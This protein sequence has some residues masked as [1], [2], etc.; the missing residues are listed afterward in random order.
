M[1][2]ELDNGYIMVKEIKRSDNESQDSSGIIFNDQ[3]LD[4][5]QVSQGT[6]IQ[7][8][9]KYKAGDT[10]LFHKV[11]PV[12]VHMKLEGDE[13]LEN[14]YFIKSTDVICKITK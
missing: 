14:Y 13:R 6:I 4:D 10:I 1:L 12:D 5:E 3:N 11:I 2:I 9:G 7:D 8:A